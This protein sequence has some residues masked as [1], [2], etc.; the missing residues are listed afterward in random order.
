MSAAASLLAQAQ[1]LVA[2]GRLEEAR[3]ALAGGD[4]GDEPLWAEAWRLLAK[5][6]LHLGAPQAARAAMERALSADPAL[7]EGGFEMGV[8][9]LANGCWRDAADRFAGVLAA[10]PGHG[11]ALFNRA[12]ALAKAGDAAAEDAYR[13]CLAANPAQV[14]AWF[15]LGNWLAGQ[16][17]RAAEAEACYRRALALAPARADITHN[18]A[19]ILLE[20][21][22]AAE[23]E[24]L[25]RDALP[26]VAPSGHA[27]LLAVL[28]RALAARGEAGDALAAL[29]QAH[30]LAPGDS[31]IRHNLA[32]ALFQAGHL[33]QAET[34]LAPLDGQPA[35]LNLRAALA[36]ARFDAHGAETLLRRALELAPDDA[37]ARGNLG[38]A[39][40][41][42]G[43]ADAALA[44]FRRAHALAPKDAAI[45]SNLLFAL[46]HDAGTDPDTL[47]REHRRFGD[48][49]EALAP[50]L[51]LPSPRPRHGRKLRLG[52]VSPDFRDHAVMLLLEPV[53]R[54]HD[55]RRF[56]I[57][58]YFT[59]PRQDAVSRRV[60][61]LVDCFHPIAHLSPLAAARRIRDDGIDILVD[62]AG[63]S[64]GNGLPIFVHR[65]APL[66]VT[67]LGYP[68]TSGLTRMDV[69]L[70]FGGA[71]PGRR[72]PWGTERLVGFAA[73][74]LFQPP[75]AAPPVAPPPSLAGGGV[76]FGS[77]NRAG[78]VN[79]EVAAQWARVLHRV[80][81]S[82]LLMMA[83][84]GDAAEVRAH[85]HGLFAPHGIAAERLDIRPACALPQ[86]LDLM[87]QVDVA[88]DPFP[89]GGGTTT[90]LTLWQ[91]LPLVA[92][93]GAD[94]RQGTSATL[95]IG[96][97]LRDLVAADADGY[98]DLACRLAVDEPR[99]LRLRAETRARLMLS[100]MMDA[101]GRTRDLE[102]TLTTLWD[103]RVGGGSDEGE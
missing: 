54:H 73:Y 86:F 28:A 23:A 24:A 55:R 9:L 92:L 52:Y 72:D 36:L 93:G 91:G 47:A 71:P 64:A 37:Q 69:R 59:A 32:L 53:L 25:L 45:H 11:G 96:C 34:V 4:L 78:K 21:G 89:Y 41:L 33:D 84:S 70:G 76:V 42:Q 81:G 13:A 94:L 63:H 101:A 18:L 98:V 27:P 97:G 29:R 38:K 6:H 1:A 66:Q 39:L 68:C 80:A 88:L 14:D 31:D 44:Q 58:C 103:H 85:L 102:N 49:Q 83:E 99:R 26:R 75:E 87:A 8:I 19:A 62:L 77:L 35:A 43:Q 79:A 7:P 82:R 15:N 60:A 3:A 5:L 40:A 74:P 61:E 12:W 57:H 16:D 67:W 100:P 46:C 20:G 95:L 22:Q 65:P 50:P 2:A 48:I 30:A 10:Q 56:E 51:D 90:L 17:G